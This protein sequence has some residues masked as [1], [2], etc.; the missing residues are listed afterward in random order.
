MVLLSA[1]VKSLRPRQWTKN[2][3]LFA[4]LIFTGNMKDLHLL[5]R[6]ILGFI[7]FCTL[8]G[9]M[10]LVNDVRDMESDRQ[11]P[12]K[13]HRP[14][15]SGELPVH[16]ALT[17]AFLLGVPALGLSYYRIGVA[18]GNCALAYV[19]LVTLYSL[20]FKNHVI[21]D[22]L[23]VA[24]GFVVRA[25]AGIEAM[26][27]KGK[28]PE[29][30]PWFLACTLF[31]ALFLAICKRRHEITLLN[32]R[33]SEHRQVL[34]EYSPAFLDQMMAVT[35]T[36]TVLSY[37]LWST[38]GTIGKFA[39]YRMMIYTLPFVLYGIFRYLYHVYQKEE[40]GAPESILLKDR[41]L[42]VNIL[43]W[44]ISIII[45]IYFYKPT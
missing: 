25:V 39:G 33:A 8:S 30:T 26:A 4:G 7:L 45:L 41:P 13:R 19:I 6:S 43:L 29:V 3:L 23:M 24:L 14:I 31:L 1:L 35:T 17:A 16:V 11:H 42:Q 34:E 27:V 40:G 18:F 21:I 44:V 32:N 2:L 10:Y 12:E 22:L 20:K 28:T 9:V 36:A 38:I 5:G 15:A 37:A